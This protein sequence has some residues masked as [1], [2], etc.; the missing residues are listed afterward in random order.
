MTHESLPLSETVTDVAANQTLVTI[1]Q[2]QSAHQKRF[3]RMIHADGT[4]TDGNGN[5]IGISADALFAAS[6][7]EPISR[8]GGVKI[9]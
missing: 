5:P 7:P 2:A 1:N 3:M 9:S 6:I 8:I 4:V